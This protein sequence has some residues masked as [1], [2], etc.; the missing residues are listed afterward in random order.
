MNKLN[1]NIFKPGKL[2]SKWV[3]HKKI[4]VHL[5][6]SKQFDDSNCPSCGCQLPFTALSMCTVKFLGK[7]E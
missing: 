4:A 5:F 7:T 1:K 3:E 2:M 6:P